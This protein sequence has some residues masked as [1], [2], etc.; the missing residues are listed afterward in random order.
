[1]RG[2]SV[3]KTTTVK[4]MTC[5]EIN[6]IWYIKLGIFQSNVTCFVAR[7]LDWNDFSSGNEPA[8][9]LLLGA[10]QNDVLKVTCTTV[11][12]WFDILE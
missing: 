8:I 3:V 1:M 11:P 6:G 9:F 5:V 2:L 10:L 4:D 12:R 7:Y